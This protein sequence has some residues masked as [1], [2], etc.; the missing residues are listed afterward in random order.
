MFF[1][2]T[3]SLLRIPTI[4]PNVFP[5]GTRIGVSLDWPCPI[6][7]MGMAK[8]SVCRPTED[9]EEILNTHKYIVDIKE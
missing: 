6:G 7:G 9:V 4:G 2:L 1:T 8:F 3:F 5:L